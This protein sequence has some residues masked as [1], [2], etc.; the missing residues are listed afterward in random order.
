MEEHDELPIRM[1][2]L[3]RRHR[4]QSFDEVVGQPHIVR[5]LRNAV[6]QDK[7]HH[8]YL[9]VGS[10]G[11]GKTSIAKIL[12]R[13]LN[14]VNGPTVTPCGE[15]ESCRSIAN[16]TSLDVI[17]MDA[18]SN[19]SVD[20]IRDLREKVGFAP[21]LGRS[22]VYI[23]DE[24]HMLSKAAWDAFLKTLEEPPPNTIFVL[25]TTEPH[26]V[27]A[28]IV[29]RCH[30][31][32]FQRPSLEEITVVLRRIA[33]AEQIGAD[34]RTFATIARSAAG[35]F[36]DA[37]GTLDQLVTY[38]GKQVSFED[39]LDVLNVADADLIFRTTDALIA[40]DP[41]AALECVEELISTGRDP[42]QFMD[43]LTAHLRQLVVVQAVGK[44]PDSFSVTA[45]QTD[46][47]TSQAKE[48]SQL[49]AVRAIDLVAEAIRA[50]KDGSEA[51]LQLE[52][53]L[54]KGAR[55]RADA[56][57]EA[58]NVRIE[59]LEQAVSRA[60]G[61]PEGAEPGGGPRT[62]GPEP[63]HSPSRKR[64]T[65]AAAKQPQPAAA[66]QAAAVK[67][68]A[69][70]EL[71]ELSDLQARWPVVLQQIGASEGEMLRALLEGA[72]PASL[73]ENLLVI[74]Y[75]A[76]AEFRKRKVESPANQQRITEAL[77]HVTGQTLR[78]SFELD[79]ESVDAPGQGSLL[80]EEEAIAAF[81]DTFDAEDVAV[82]SSRKETDEPP[83]AAEG[84]DA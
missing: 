48:I 19:N 60:G 80:S 54:L 56:S 32:D 28:T 66:K 23:L 72:Q 77:R 79:E 63:E 36:R 39:V 57:I 8:A 59:R 20:D 27:L 10:R 47:L 1:T 15:C 73:E 25:A 30:R 18:A 84:E 69:A 64:I 61:G 53:A 29:D 43:D 2:S 78:L 34:D 7:V 22:K 37:I 16:S 24:A 58:L 62:G 31:F 44:V 26:K 46:R 55:P 9:F 40:G 5:T 42:R 45:D 74:S 65:G 52:L 41:R 13:S 68:A 75:P 38:G 76:S 50:V 51:R 11:T 70:G 35:S 12:A 17:E 21:A 83:R 67:E 3:Y 6:E 33:D 82:D 14:C 81:R 4:P 49:E 71:T